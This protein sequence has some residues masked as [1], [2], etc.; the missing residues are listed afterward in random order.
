[1]VQDVY[2]EATVLGLG[3]VMVGG[4]E[5]SAVRRALGVPAGWEAL[6]LMPVG[7]RK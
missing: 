4:F 3:T 5:E 1:V 6:A 2:L 7:R